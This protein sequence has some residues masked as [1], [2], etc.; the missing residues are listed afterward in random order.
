MLGGHIECS[1][2]RV[3]PVNPL[4]GDLLAGLGADRRET[5][6]QDAPGRPN[7]GP[8]DRRHSEELGMRPPAGSS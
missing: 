5:A 1:S 4:G 3:L 8:P 2:N 6:S 7:A